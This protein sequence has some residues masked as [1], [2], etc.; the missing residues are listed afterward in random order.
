[1]I[2]DLYWSLDY[3]TGRWHPTIGDPTFMGWFTVVAYFAC[4]VMAYIVACKVRKVDR[5]AFQFWV[6][7][8][9]ILVLLG[10]NKQLDLQTLLT[11]MGRQVAHA[12]GWYE[13]RRGFQL[14]FIE[15]FVIVLIGAYVLFAIKMKAF[16]KGFTLAFTGLFF[17]MSFVIIRAASFHHVDHMLK[18][19]FLGAKTNWI[20]ELGGIFTIIAAALRE[21]TS[22]RISGK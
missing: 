21:I 12:Q 9:V 1:M 5:R 7:A 10:I 14:H 20:L 17:L 11:E 6:T 13:E 16:F 4:A 3:L 18:L 15:L 22:K 2:S 8:F 19:R